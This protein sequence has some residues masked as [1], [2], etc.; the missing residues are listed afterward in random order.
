MKFLDLMSESA[1]VRKKDERTYKEMLRLPVHK[2]F[3]LAIEM[4]IAGGGDALCIGFQRDKPVDANTWKEERDRAAL[5]TRDM[6]KAAGGTGYGRFH[7]AGEG[8]ARLH[9]RGGVPNVPIWFRK[10]D[11][12]YMSAGIPIRLLPA[13]LNCIDERLVSLGGSDR[14]PQPVRYIEYFSTD[15]EM[16]RYVATLPEPR[17][18]ELAEHFPESDGP[19]NDNRFFV[20]VDLELRLDN[21][22][23]MYFLGQREVDGTV[24]V[25]RHLS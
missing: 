2:L 19:E 15:R 6:P 1:R 23:W 7:K 20:E 18:S 3:S 25:Q 4:A 17:R 12:L 16:R 8:N 5:Q 9:G 10:D 14:S 21:T 22:V 13:F 11:Q 24:N